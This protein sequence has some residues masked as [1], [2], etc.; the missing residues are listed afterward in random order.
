MKNLALIFQR[1]LLLP[2]GFLLILPFFSIVFCFNIFI[3]Q[4][5]SPIFLSSSKSPF[6]S[7][8]LNNWCDNLSCIY[9]VPF[10]SSCIFPSNL[11]LSH[12]K[13]T[14][15]TYLPHDL[16]SHS[17]KLPFAAHST[18]FHIL[19]I[20]YS[21]AFGLHDILDWG[22]YIIPVAYYLFAWWRNAVNWIKYTKVIWC[23]FIW[24]CSTKFFWV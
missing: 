10:A 22:E 8:Q 11:H 5:P 4:I 7:S 21:A 24:Y 19:D 2:P 6:M 12:P 23:S 20:W 18:S 14:S 1:F 9:F 3:P 13:P 17:P 16:C 15:A